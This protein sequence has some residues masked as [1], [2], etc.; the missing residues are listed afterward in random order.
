[1]TTLSVLSAKLPASGGA[2]LRHFPL[3]IISRAFAESARDG[4]PGMLYVH[5]WEV[6]PGQPRLP[7]SAITRLRHYGG[8]EGTLPRLDRMLREFQFG[9]VRDWLA[10]R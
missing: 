4:S 7:V 5:P 2:Y 1:M 3:W 10:S 6:D 8:I 9:S